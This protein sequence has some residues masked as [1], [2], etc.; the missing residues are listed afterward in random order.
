MERRV[1][2]GGGALG[3]ADRVDPHGRE[4][5]EVG[6]PVVRQAREDD[7][8]V[9]L[10]LAVVAGVVAQLADELAA[11]VCEEEMLAATDR[12]V[13]ERRGQHAEPSLPL[14]EN[15]HLLDVLVVIERDKTIGAAG[16][17]D[18]GV[19][20]GA[21]PR[22]EDSDII[23]R[24]EVAVPASDR[25]H[26]VQAAV[27]AGDEPDG[28][29]LEPEAGGDNRSINE[30]RVVDDHGSFDLRRSVAGGT[31]LGPRTGGEPFYNEECDEVRYRAGIRDGSSAEFLAQA[32]RDT[33]RELRGT[34]RRSGRGR[35]LLL[36]ALA[37]GGHH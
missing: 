37:L 1:G 27:G 19:G 6:A 14:S 35:G 8:A 29:E 20:M 5:G 34:V 7:V 2:W 24:V 9:A 15:S 30:G 22:R 13:W 18:R 32:T 31:G 12:C 26:L 25:G 16:H 3:L 11:G 33:D 21:S 23:R 17:A 10:D 28:E 4:R 36:V